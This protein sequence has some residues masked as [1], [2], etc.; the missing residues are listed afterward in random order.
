MR[1]PTTKEACA[2]FYFQDICLRS[3]H[4]R[5]A[6]GGLASS[7]R[8]AAW[9]RSISGSIRPPISRPLLRSIDLVG[10][11]AARDRVGSI[12]VVVADPTFDPNSPQVAGLEGIEEDAFVFK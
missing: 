8:M 1:T 6:R 11:A 4:V 12:G 5:D 9:L 10:R 7:D 2:A 3:F